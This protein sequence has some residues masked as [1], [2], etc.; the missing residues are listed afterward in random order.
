MTLGY[1]RSGMVSGLKG[2]MSR[3]RLGLTAI[4]RR[5]ELY[6][7]LLVGFTSHKV[8]F[9]SSD[10][11]PLRTKSVFVLSVTLLIY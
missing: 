11:I 9:A 10:K 5:F 4:R 7:C 3:L 8:R 2:Q 1:P 6:E